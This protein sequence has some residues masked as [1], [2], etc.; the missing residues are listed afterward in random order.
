MIIGPAL[1]DGEESFDVEVCTPAW[2]A[3]RY[4]PHGIVSGRH[5]LIVFEYDFKVIDSYLREFVANC[6]GDTWQ[7]VA[8]KIGRL[9]HWEFEDYSP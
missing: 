3:Q 1:Q 2:L 5:H 7:D 4:G 9:G 8:G 6:S